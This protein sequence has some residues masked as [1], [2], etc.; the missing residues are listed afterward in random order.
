MSDGRLLSRRARSLVLGL[1]LDRV[2]RR[3]ALHRLDALP[4]RLFPLV[5]LAGG[6]DLAVARYQVEVE[7]AALTLFQHVLTAH[8]APRSGCPPVDSRVCSV[9][10]F[11]QAV[12]SCRR[13]SAATRPPSARPA[14]CGVTVFITF[15]MAGIPVAPVSAMAA[16]TRD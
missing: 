14:T 16:A 6:D 15:P 5:V 2:G 4:G 9:T 10:D 1:V 7:L 13:T 3:V 8:R 12:P 11:T